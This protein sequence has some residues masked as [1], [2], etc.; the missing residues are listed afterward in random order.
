MRPRRERIWRAVT[1]PATNQPKVPLSRT[2]DTRF[3][4]C[5]PLRAVAALSVGTFH[6]FAVSTLTWRHPAAAGSFAAG[7]IGR[8]SGSLSIGL[9]IFFVLSGYLLGRPFV[10]WLVT[11]DQRPRI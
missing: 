11:G 9:Y 4:V 5:D 1:T 10:R 7:W 3:Y 2:A 8:V 6:V